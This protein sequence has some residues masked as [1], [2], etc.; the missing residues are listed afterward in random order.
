MN[1][2]MESGGVKTTGWEVIGGGNQGLQMMKSDGKGRT[3][4][5]QSREM[6]WVNGNRGDP[7]ESVGDASYSS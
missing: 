4:M 6:R 2:W 7:M 3:S 5:G 1:W